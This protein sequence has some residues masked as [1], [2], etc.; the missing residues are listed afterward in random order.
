[1]E[2]LNCLLFAFMATAI[3]FASFGKSS[4]VEAV[5]CCRRCQNRNYKINGLFILPMKC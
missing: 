5:R 3:I 2:N 1:M 4:A